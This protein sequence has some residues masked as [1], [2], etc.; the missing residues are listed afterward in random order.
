ME[1]QDERG[2]LNRTMR[3]LSEANA[4]LKRTTY[5]LAEARE[6]ARLGAPTQASSP[7]TSATNHALPAPDRLVS[8]R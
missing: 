1:L 7:P 8:P 6:E 5:D 3:A 2:R 4:L